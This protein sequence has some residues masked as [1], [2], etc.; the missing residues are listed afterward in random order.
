M[1]K[2]TERGTA[3]SIRDSAGFILCHPAGATRQG[4][5][6]KRK[7]AAKDAFWAMCTAAGMYNPA[8]DMAV[9]AE[10][11]ISA[12]ARR[13]VSNREGSMD[14]GHVKADELGGAYCPCNMVPLYRA[15]NLEAGTAAPLI[16]RDPRTAWLST[17]AALNPTKAHRAYVATIAA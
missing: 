12:P 6:S 3:Y 16:E 14:M 15:V 10:T 9:C 7:S 2:H 8:T 13:G 11:G 17:W 5:N 1:T 4:Y